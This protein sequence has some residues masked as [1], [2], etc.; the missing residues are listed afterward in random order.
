MILA[1]VFCAELHHINVIDSISRD[2]Q[3]AFNGNG[4]G[5]WLLEW[6]RSLKISIREN[7]SFKWSGKVSVPRHASYIIATAFL[8]NIC[9]IHF[10]KSSRSEHSTML[11]GV[12]LK[13]NLNFSYSIYFLSRFYERGQECLFLKIAFSVSMS[14]PV[15][16]ST[17]GC[18]I[19]TIY[20][21]HTA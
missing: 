13:S 2:V 10:L 5:R 19:I 8:T 16:F 4:L 15:L 3:N 14:S 1:A 6:R 20:T 12:W 9:W 17:W 7:H 11:F 18:Q 21:K